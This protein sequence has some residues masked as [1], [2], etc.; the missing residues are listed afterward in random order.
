LRVARKLLV[1]PLAV[2]L[3]AA[4]LSTA[5][6]LAVTSGAQADAATPL[7]QL[8]AFHQMV[9][10][11]ADGYIFLSEGSS[12]ASVQNGNAGASG[13][14]VA[15]L[16]GQYVK[17][18]DAGDGVEGL[19]LDGS[20]LYAA[21]AKTGQVAAID[22]S[23]R[24]FT[25]TAYSL[26]AGD[27]PYSV[28]VQSGDVWVSYDAKVPGT[29]AAVGD[30]SLSTGKFEPATAGT[31]WDTSPD[32]AA[33]PSDS[34]VLAG[35]VS[36]SPDQV[37]IY[38]TT[39]DPA[40]GLAPLQSLGISSI[41]SSCEPAVA[42]GG[43]EFIT[44]CHS[45][46][47]AA[48][49]AVANLTTAT[50]SY[51]DPPIPTVP[52]VIAVSPDGDIAVGSSQV[53][54]V[55]Q[56]DGSLLD[57]YQIS[58]AESLVSDGLSWSAD[59][60][61]LYAVVD[62]EAGAY[63]AGPI[64][65]FVQQTSTVTLTPPASAPL[66]GGA[67]TIT[68]QL[69]FSDGTPA[70]GTP[71][72]VT[73]QGPGGSVTNTTVETDDASGGFVI[74]EAP[75]ALGTY[76]ITAQY[77][78]GTGVSGSQASTSFT[79]SLSESKV[80]LSAP[81]G[82]F[83]GVPNT[84][85]GTLTF[86]DGVTPAAGT[87][88]TVTRV[89]PGGGTP[90]SMGAVATNGTGAFSFTDTPPSAGG[91]TYTASFAGDPADAPATGTL[92]VTAAAR[93]AAITLSGPSSIAPG[94]SFTISGK[95]TITP[96]ASFDDPA[97][98]SVVRTNPNHTTTS[99]TVAAGA[100]GAFTIPG[101][102]TTLGAYSYAVSYAG[103]PSASS[104]NATRSLTVGRQSPALTLSTGASTALYGSTVHVT[105][106]LGSTDTNRTVS[107]YYQLLGTG[108]RKLLKTAKV[109]GSGNL[110]L[111]Y[112]AATRSVIFSVTFSGDAQYVPR[113]ASV[114]LGVDVRVAMTNSGWYTT[115]K[116]NGGTYHV[117][118][119]NGHLNLAVSVTPNKHD[120]KLEL[121]GQQWY[122]NAWHDVSGDVITRTLPGTSSIAGYLT[123]AQVTGAYF[124]LRA[125]FIP[126]STDVTNVSYYS[127]WFSFTVVK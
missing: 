54:Y 99:S 34:G 67:A 2:A 31:G 120:E 28:A 95:L 113:S 25:Q 110:V 27:V 47:D 114:R 66:A 42:P 30:I 56:P 119:S 4:A 29:G 123:V 40:T 50:A 86:D 24:A 49:Y 82:D 101:T 51:A 21:L 92:A 16:S 126:S 97:T 5:G 88:I 45:A 33:D 105:A 1:P 100:T 107:V 18:L 9:V 20:T 122:N 26:S 78:G 89:N 52:N 69:A 68:G 72:L 7:P 117:F 115:A 62:S 32:L 60:S 91:Y 84:I 13:I 85:S 87:P 37:A 118:H 75:A 70:A 125:V 44:N 106:H 57:T 61:V 63:S 112:P 116:F 64:T 102:L 35:S 109:N 96:G 94:K 15:T 65:G 90:V 104:A 53:V 6:F 12:A 98:I 11:A 36:E 80:G 58:N 79:V 93:R 55:Y 71:V 73:T 3:G 108:T 76:T 41:S 127:G 39:T 74:T 23:T 17:A 38:N 83:L 48:A 8:T 111:S 77:N 43:S 121:V 10:D 14:I 59:G 103:S 19:A 46:A 124:R 81:S 22:A